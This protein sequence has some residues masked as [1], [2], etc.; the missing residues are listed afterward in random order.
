M[1]D[2]LDGG[3]ILG[4][5]WP[6]PGGEDREVVGPVGVTKVIKWGLLSVGDTGGGGEWAVRARSNGS[7]RPAREMMGWIG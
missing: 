2:W 7:D 4:R 5:G 6:A 1:G 3:R